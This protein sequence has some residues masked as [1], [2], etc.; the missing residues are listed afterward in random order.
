[1]KLRYL[2]AKNVLSFRD[3]G[4][5]L[6]FD[7]YNVIVGPNDSGKTNL[8][9]VLNMRARAIKF[10]CGGSRALNKSSPERKYDETKINKLIKTFHLL[11][12]QLATQNEFLEK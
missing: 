9:R 10:F 4:I 8:F 7:P 11:E 12:E 5:E 3:E 1:M 6:E 2:K